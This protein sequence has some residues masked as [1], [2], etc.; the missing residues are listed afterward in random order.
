MTTQPR[1]GFTRVG[2]S[3]LVP[4]RARSR[5]TC[6]SGKVR[7]P[8]EPEALD[9]MMR[10]RK[11]RVRNGETRTPENRIYYC[12]QCEGWHL[13][14]RELH[15]LDLAQ[16]RE[17][18]DGEPWDVY[19]KRLERKI[20]DQRSQI[21]S[22]LALGHAGSNRDLRKRVPTLLTALG[23]MTE[24]WQGERRTRENLTEILRQKHPLV[25][26]LWKVTIGRKN[27]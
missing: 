3:N 19:A 14:S 25:W 13:S 24:R 11:E 6:G 16:M 21:V 7:Y 17:R 27:A 2:V 22:L 20:A 4:W 10:V 15:P 9:A 26:L 12:E 23:Q 8:S 18:G 1:T 5:Y